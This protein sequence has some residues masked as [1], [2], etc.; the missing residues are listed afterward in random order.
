MILLFLGSLSKSKLRFED[1]FMFSLQKN[2]EKT[3][4][5]DF[6]DMISWAIVSQSKNMPCWHVFVEMSFDPLTYWRSWNNCDF[7]GRRTNN[8]NNNMAIK[9]L[10]GK[11]ACIVRENMQVGETIRET[12]T[13]KRLMK[14]I[15]KKQVRRKNKEKT[16]ETTKKMNKKLDTTNNG[17]VYGLLPPPK[18]C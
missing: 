1:C 2:H 6:H 17:T 13:S 8:F 18:H 7:V 10:L 3:F 4:R 16:S 9:P 15:F 14:I 5:N 11:S 12:L